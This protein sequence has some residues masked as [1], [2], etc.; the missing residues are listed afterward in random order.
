VS[1]GMENELIVTGIE[2]SIIG[3]TA[4]EHGIPLHELASRRASLEAAF[5]ELTYDSVEFRADGKAPDLADIQE[6]ARELTGRG[7]PR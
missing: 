3:E 5:M 1:N 4:A 2:A 6:T 7:A